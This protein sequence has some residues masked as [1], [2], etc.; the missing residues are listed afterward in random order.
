MMRM[1]IYVALVNLAAIVLVSNFMAL[2]A[3]YANSNTIRSDGYLAGW[4]RPGSSNRPSS[5]ALADDLYSIAAVEAS[6]AGPRGRSPKLSRKV[7]WHPAVLVVVLIVSAITVGLT[8]IGYRYQ[9]QVDKSTNIVRKREDEARLG[10]LAARQARYVADIRQAAVYIAKSQPRN[11]VDLLMRQLP[12]PGEDDLREFSWHHLLK[13]CHTERRTLTGHRGEVYYVEFSPRG[14]LLATAGKD[15]TVHLWNTTTWQPVRTISASFTEANVA[16]FSPDGKTIATVD[17]DGKLKIWET[18]T[19][20]CQLEKVAH[21]G[22]G[23]MARFTP[24]GKLIVTAGRTDGTAKLWEVPSG[25]ELKAFAANGAIL[26]MDGSM[27]AILSAAEVQLWNV[28]N[29]K[30]IRSFAGGRG[31]AGGAF[32]HDGTRIATADEADRWVR[33][34]DVGT[35]VMIHEFHG[36]TEGATA[37][38][39]SVDDRTIISA[40]DDYTIRFW[41]VTTGTQRGVHL[42]H[43]ARIW[44]LA[45]SPDGGT[46][47]SASRDETVKLWDLKA[48]GDYFQASDH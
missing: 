16:T 6:R 22:N 10:A 33:L 37:A 42:G 21:I 15:G 4:H 38:V 44:N 12:K 20:Q 2:I 41:D 14:D 34:W 28:E 30:L 39:F 46:I 23:A 25:Q 11:A 3:Y 35:R 32:S 1:A 13:R 36:H 48:P 18:A 27:L 24:D 45:V 43:A 26:S 31:I 8:S 7:R 19:G 9:A 17:D 47:A 40:G 5:P 29:R